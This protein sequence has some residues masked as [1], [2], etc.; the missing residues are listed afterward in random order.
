MYVISVL[1]SPIRANFA[2]ICTV[3]SGGLISAFGIYVPWLFAGSIISTVG[4]G[5]IYTLDIGTPSSKWIG[6]QALAGIGLG[7]SF[8]V[9]IIANQAFVDISEI[10]AITAVTLCRHLSSSFDEHR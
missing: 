3:V 5:L 9:P 7:L 1:V 10:S 8:Q 2:A 6:Y 4:I